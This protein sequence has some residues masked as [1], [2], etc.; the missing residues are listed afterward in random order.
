ML[1]FLTAILGDDLGGKLAYI[2]NGKHLAWYASLRYTLIAAVAGAGLAVLFGLLGA[3]LKLSRITPLR[4]IGNLY[5]T[6]IRGIPDVLFLLF[7]PLAF[8]HLVEAGMAY[9]SCSPEQLAGSRWPPCPD[10]QWFLSSTEY[11][12]M[13]CVSFGIVYGAFA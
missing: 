6:M 3:G 1:E 11:L 13:A 8:E 10:A 9:L 12:I 5:T 4:W 2:T 7:F